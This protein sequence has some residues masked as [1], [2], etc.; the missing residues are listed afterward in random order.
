M[1]GF[2]MPPASREHKVPP[3]YLQLMVLKQGEFTLNRFFIALSAQPV[4]FRR[5]TQVPIEQMMAEAPKEGLTIQGYWCGTNR[6][7]VEVPA[8]QH[9]G[10]HQGLLEEAEILDQA[11]QSVAGLGGCLG[12]T[13]M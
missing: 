2:D 11:G 8:E 9:A 4:S 1:A 10:K 3:L 13:G 5:V 6:Q 7:F 12:P